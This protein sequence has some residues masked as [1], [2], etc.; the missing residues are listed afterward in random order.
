MHDRDDRNCRF[1]AHR[2]TAR[3][4]IAG[5]SVA[6]TLLEPIAGIANEPHIAIAQGVPKGQKM[7]FVVEAHRARRRRDI[8]VSI[9]AH[10]RTRR[11]N[12]IERWRRLAK[13]ARSSADARR[14]P[15]FP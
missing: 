12:K 14:F 15:P 11:A 3:V 5:R 2:F 13:S 1:A 4:A 10:D 6:A 9:G 7:D 8:A